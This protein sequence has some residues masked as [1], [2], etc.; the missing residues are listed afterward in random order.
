MSIDLPPHDSGSQPALAF[1]PFSEEDVRRIR[2]WQA[3][4]HVHP[5]RT[6]AAGYLICCQQSMEVTVDGLRCRK[7]GRQQDW[8]PGT[9]LEIDLTEPS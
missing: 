3:S 7:C 4:I 5:R 8:V 1:A 2:Q 6:E 9:V